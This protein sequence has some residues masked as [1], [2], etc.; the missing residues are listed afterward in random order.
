M[1]GLLLYLGQPSIAGV[2]K[3]APVIS[4]HGTPAHFGF[5]FN[6]PAP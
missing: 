6:N 2:T 1:Q 4:V 5:Q 3:H